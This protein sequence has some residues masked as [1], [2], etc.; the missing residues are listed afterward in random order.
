MLDCPSWES[1][2]YF[3]TFGPVAN[4]PLPGSRWF[5]KVPG[6]PEKLF[7]KKMR[8]S[9]DITISQ[10]CWRIYPDKPLKKIRQKWSVAPK[11]S[12]DFCHRQRQRC[13]SL[14]VFVGQQDSLDSW[15]HYPLVRLSLRTRK[16]PFWR[17]KSSIDGPC[18][19]AMLNYQRVIIPKW[20]SYS[21]L[22]VV[23]IYSERWLWCWGLDDL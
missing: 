21:A 13:G 6:K 9:P 5:K 22:W 11:A 16:S 1:L 10:K 4:D 23:V 19:I 18:S 17:S 7:P 20:P 12:W 2:D 15:C 14:G 3:D 8:T